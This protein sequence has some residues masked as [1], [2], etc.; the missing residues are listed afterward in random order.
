VAT[1]SSGVAGGRADHWT[2]INGIF[3]RPR[4]SCPWRDLPEG[5]GN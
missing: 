1:R 2:M 5:F 4:A 3:F